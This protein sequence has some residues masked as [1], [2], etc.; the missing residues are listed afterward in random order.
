M[1]VPDTIVDAT[2]GMN[3]F[4]SN[5]DRLEEMVRAYGFPD[6]QPIPMNQD[7][8][9][10]LV[11]LVVQLPKEIAGS[12]N[13]AQKELS[14]YLAA[15]PPQRRLMGVEIHA[16]HLVSLLMERLE[17][18]EQL[19]RSLVR[20]CGGR[21]CP[22]FKVCP[23]KPIVENLVKDDAIPCAVERE[24]IRTNVEN[25]VTPQNGSK[26]RVDPR[27]PEMAL[28]F[29]QLIQLL[30]KQVRISMYLQE[31]DIWIETWE[32]LKDGDMER[33]DTA[34]KMVH[35]LMDAWDRNQASITRTLKDMGLNV[36]FQIKQ[37]IWIDEASQV[38]SEK[39]A[40]ELAHDLLKDGLEQQ[41]RLLPEGT[42]ERIMLEQAVTMA[43]A[44]LSDLK[45]T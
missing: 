41:L 37:G 38:D 42:P 1:S 28:L 2:A 29:K 39:R 21:E 34:N 3:P 18:F 30:V 17:F 26:P 10:D 32:I 11:S 43:T 27:R 20:M 33:F 24:V 19:S 14:E 45:S 36:E 9:V 8:F 6:D 12:M 5:E 23:F 7:G 13:P 35:P 15:I 22:H 31:H 16:E 40:I 4:Q 25:F 44:R